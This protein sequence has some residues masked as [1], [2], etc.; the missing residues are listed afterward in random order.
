MGCIIIPKLDVNSNEHTGFLF[1]SDFETNL[2]E[3]VEKKDE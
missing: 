2:S 1:Q 3:L